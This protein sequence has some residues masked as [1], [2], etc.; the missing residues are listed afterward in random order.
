M[1]SSEDDKRWR[2]NSAWLHHI[3]WIDWNWNL[4]SVCRQTNYYIFFKHV[5]PIWIARRCFAYSI[6]DS[7]S[8]NEISISNGLAV[9]VW[10]QWPR[11]PDSLNW[12]QIVNQNSI[13]LEHFRANDNNIPYT[14]HKNLLFAIMRTVT[15][16]RHFEMTW[17]TI[18]LKAQKLFTTMCQ[19]DRQY[20][21]RNV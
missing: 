5:W 13:Q 11:P 10:R 6:F 1:S 21:N 4:L 18:F 15:S 8:M 3:V 12:L 17:E 9:I 20:A 2:K 16:R 19:V 7:H 14:L